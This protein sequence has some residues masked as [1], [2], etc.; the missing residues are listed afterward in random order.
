[1]K[2]GGSFVFFV[3]TVFILVLLYS[4]D[5]ADSGIFPPC[6]VNY[7]TGLY[8]PGCGSLRALHRILHGNFIEALDL[9][10]LMVIMLP[11]VALLFFSQQVLMFTGRKTFFPV[12]FKKWFY[13]VLLSAIFIFTIARNIPVYP[14]SLLKP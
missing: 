10:P 4:Y 9:N 12:H 11:F 2:K 6:P 1:M 14:F 13:Y 5:P 3:V 8:C 7:L